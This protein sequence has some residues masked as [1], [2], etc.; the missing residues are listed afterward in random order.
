MKN[1][2][3]AILIFV[4]AFLPAQQT[5]FKAVNEDD[6]MR[7]PFFNSSFSEIFDQPSAWKAITIHAEELRN[8]G[9]HDFSTLENL[10]DVHIQFTMDPDE[11]DSAKTAFTDSIAAWMKNME[12]FAKCPK[13]KRVIFQVGERIYLNKIECAFRNKKEK[14]KYEAYYKRTSAL[15]LAAAWNS[16][17]KDVHASLPGVELYAYTWGW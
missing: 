13:L 8:A 7:F 3:S 15:N 2:I 17:G 5:A 16:F 14:R 10:E 1:F 6:D 9:G 12:H 4:P 11:S